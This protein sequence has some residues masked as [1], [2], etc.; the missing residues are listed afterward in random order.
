MYFI[1]DIGG[2]KI[3]AAYSRDGQ[4][5]GVPRVIATPPGAATGVVEI[6]TLARELSAGGVIRRAAGGVASPF[7]ER[8]EILAHPPHL[9]GWAGVALR[10]DLERALGAPVAI[11]N[12]AAL[13]GLGE[14][15]AG[16]GKGARIIAYLT[17]STGVGGTRIVDGALDRAAFGFEPGHQIIDLVGAGSGTRAGTL[18]DFISGTAVE[19][20][21][22]TPPANIVNPAVW[23]ELAR[24]LAYGL[25]NTIVHWSPEAVVLGG[26]MM[27]GKNGIKV[28]KVREHLSRVST[29]FPKLPEIRQATLG[30][31][32]GLHGALALLRQSEAR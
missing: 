20:R 5:F 12:D 11:E 25:H 9:P 7:G 30:D 28:E 26:S 18:E 2:T 21:F 29:I 8:G 16:A 27:L 23:D 10:R 31:F 6:A 15:H 32:G 19:R 24:Y 4:T 17:V 1:F 22:G 13:A 14:A 3:R